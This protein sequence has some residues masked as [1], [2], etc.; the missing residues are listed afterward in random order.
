MGLLATALVLASPALAETIHLKGGER[1]KGRIIGITN[2]TITVESEKGYGVL[3]IPRTDVLLIEYQDESRDPSRTMGI[4]Y[5]HR[6]APVTGNGSAAEYAVDAISL[7]YW[8]DAYDSLDVQVGFFSA[9]NDGDKELEV[10]S[11]DLRYATVVKRQ[12]DM[13]LYIGGSLGYLQVEDNTTA[14]PVDDSGFGVRAFAG[15]E[16]FFVT[17]PNLGIAGE[18]G[19]GTQQV[20]NRS[21]TSISTSSFPSFSVRYYF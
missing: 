4:G 20:G 15:V 6:S 3:Q 5:H 16:V 17:L 21:T 10:F 8:L 18:V 2:E 11:M 13:D 12:A 9:I 1:V 19:I 7:K 14:D